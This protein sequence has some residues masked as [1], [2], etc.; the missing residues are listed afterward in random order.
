MPCSADLVLGIDTSPSS[1]AMEKLAGGPFMASVLPAIARSV[2]AMKPGEQLVVFKIS[3]S[4]VVDVPL[5][6]KRIQLAR[7]AEGDTATAY[8]QSLPRFVAEHIERHRLA[9]PAGQS[10]LTAAVANARNLVRPGQP[11]QLVVVSDLVE[12]DSTGLQYPRDLAKP[13][14]RNPRLD[15]KGCGFTAYGAVQHLSPRQSQALLAHWETWLNAAGAE[16]VQ[17]KRF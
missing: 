3:S 13:L 15:L 7:T 12:W 10:H 16:S 2:A 1:P 11:C 17:L 4:Q 9:P 14:P 6:N 5:L 8:A